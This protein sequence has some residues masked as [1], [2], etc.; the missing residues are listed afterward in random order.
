VLTKTTPI[1]TPFIDQPLQDNG[2]LLLTQMWGEFEN[3]T[4][5]VYIR[6]AALSHFA[7]HIFWRAEGQDRPRGSVVHMTNGQTFT[8]QES[9]EAIAACLR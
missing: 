1:V 6:P 8:V 4:R 2:L 5:D 3:K 9:P 7:E